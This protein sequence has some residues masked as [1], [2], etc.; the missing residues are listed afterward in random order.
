[1]QIGDVVYLGK[2][3][4]GT[5]ITGVQ[6]NNAA[7]GAGVTLATGYLPVSETG[8]NAAYFL[9][10]AAASSLGVRRSDAF[11]LTITQDTYITL[12]VAGGVATGA[13]E[14]IIDYVYSGQ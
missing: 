10:A 5:K 7:M 9:P 2:L 8:G 1:A 4:G 13:V 14:A 11:V 3:P 6:V 12:T